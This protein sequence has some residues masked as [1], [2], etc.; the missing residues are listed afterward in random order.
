M[1]EVFIC[2]E[3]GVMTLLLMFVFSAISAV[4]INDGDASFVATNCV[5]LFSFLLIK[6][7]L[8]PPVFPADSNG[9]LSTSFV[10]TAWAILIGSVC[11]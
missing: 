1:T 3:S 4:L 11:V 9:L 6:V 10:Q 2:A 8:F 7:I 5:F